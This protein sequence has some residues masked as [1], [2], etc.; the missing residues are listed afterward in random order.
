LLEQNLI[1]LMYA[2]PDGTQYYRKVHEVS[3]FTDVRDTV[4]AIDAERDNLGSV[5]D[6]KKQQ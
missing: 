3:S 1:V 6:P 5:D 2:T 4:T